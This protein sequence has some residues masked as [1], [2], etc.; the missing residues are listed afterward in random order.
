[1][2]TIFLVFLFHVTYD[3]ESIS[4]HSYFVARLHSQKCSVLLFRVEGSRWQFE[5]LD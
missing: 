3:I 4:G 5:P 1:M 2:H